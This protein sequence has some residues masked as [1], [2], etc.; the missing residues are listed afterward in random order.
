MAYMKSDTSDIERFVPERWTKEQKLLKA[1]RV[2]ASW[3]ECASFEEYPPELRAVWRELG[4]KWLDLSADFM[5]PDLV[6]TSKESMFTLDDQMER[7]AVFWDCSRDLDPP[8]F[9]DENF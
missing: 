6:F 3:L 8:L 9:I 2:A 7:A 5:G 1:V 4:K